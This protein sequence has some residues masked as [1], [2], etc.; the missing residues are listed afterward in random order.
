MTYAVTRARSGLTGEVLWDAKRNNTWQLA[1]SPAAELVLFILRTQ[2]GKCLVRPDLGVDWSRV[3]KLRTDARATAEAAV[4]DA[5]AEPVRSGAIRDVEVAA[6][7]YPSR[8]LLE[9]DV[10]FVDVRL[11]AQTRTTL[12]TLRQDV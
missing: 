1:Q 9:L 8:S 10:S 12:P 3:N 6:R 4:R 2:K 11:R 5:L 7:V